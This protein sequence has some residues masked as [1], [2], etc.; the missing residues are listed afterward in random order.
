MSDNLVSLNNVRFAHQLEPILDDFN[1]CWP[2]GKHL[3]IL[4]SNG[5]GK[6]TL[7]QLITDTLRPNRGQCSY[8]EHIGP[9]DIA[10]IS[11][12]QHRQLMEHDRRFDDS[13]TRA[14]AFDVGTR[15]RDAILQGGVADE[16]FDQLCQRL[17]IEHILDRGIRFI[18]TGESR[19]TLL[20]RALLAKP[21]AL[22]IDNP[23]E[24]LDA[25]AQADIRQLLDELVASPTPVLLLTKSA[26]DIPDGIDE[27]QIMSQGSITGHCS[28][29]RFVP[30]GVCSSIPPPL[31]RV[32]LPR[33]G[34]SQK[35]LV[36]DRGYDLM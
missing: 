9:G 31:P 16:N 36:S 15:V 8:G 1:W 20:A 35:F 18:S 19:K 3:A 6:T 30:F 14:D 27:V 4:G 22:I 13:E 32:R 2:K 26:T 10:H 23:L 12:D 5:C 7:A 25:Q 34:R 29:A 28:P 21:A 33:Q 17:R 24:G 11:F